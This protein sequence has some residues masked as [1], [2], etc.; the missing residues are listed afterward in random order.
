MTTDETLPGG[1]GSE[2]LAS[3]GPSHARTGIPG[4]R[5]TGRVGRQVRWEKEWAAGRAAV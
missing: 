2:T 5:E 4:A 1:I 3:A